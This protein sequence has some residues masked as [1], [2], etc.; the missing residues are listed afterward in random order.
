M[1]RFEIPE[2]HYNIFKTFINLAP[3]VKK[4][5]SNS[6]ANVSFDGNI[7]ELIDKVDRDL[8]GKLNKDQIE[9][10]VR[11]YL[12]LVNLKN[13]VDEDV[14]EA[15]E[16][17]LSNA[18]AQTEENDLVPSK[19]VID[20]FMGLILSSKSIFVETKLLNLQIENQKIFLSIEAFQDIR[21]SFEAHG[22]VEGCAIINNLKITYRE[23]DSINHFFIALDND[24]LDKVL[25][26]IKKAQA[27]MENIH[28]TFPNVLFLEKKDI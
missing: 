18:L 28:K 5:I 4:D 19:Q 16:T 8:N 24:D 21:P 14:D 2:R 27:N 17:L 25:Q 15:F 20:D 23:N 12:N 13:S 11:V 7:K 10:V 9:D 3:D 22:A 1:A 6:L 26:S